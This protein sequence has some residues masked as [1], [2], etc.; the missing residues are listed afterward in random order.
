MPND[1]FRFKQFTIRQ[2]RCA[3]KVGTDGVLLGAWTEYRDA[4]RIL[5]I[6]TGTGVLALIAAQRNGK[7]QVEAVELDP[8]SAQQARENVAESPWQRRVQV[9]EADIRNWKPDHLFDLILCNPPFYKD[10]P[11][12]SDSR[13]AKA[14]HEGTL[15]LE[16]L[17]QAID[18]LG[19]GTVRASLILPL[20]RLDELE[21]V[22]G[23]MGLS[24][25]RRCFVYHVPHKPAK[26]AL[27]ELAR[28][29]K[30]DAAQEELVIHDGQGGYTWAYRALLEDLELD[31]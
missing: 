28:R 4:R 15:D 30:G 16:A 18:R 20:H 21:D 9:H 22:A 3:L 6:G 27:V 1:F 19:T 2:D 10:H 14:R 23:R 24:A 31:F 17:V 5:D 8:A 12:S 13:A 29:E 26:R 25:M 7:A 11:A